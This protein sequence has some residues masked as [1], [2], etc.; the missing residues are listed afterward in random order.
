MRAC[1]GHLSSNL[2][3][4][5]LAVF[6]ESFS[7]GQNH[8]PRTSLLPEAS[9]QTEGQYLNHSPF[10]REGFRKTLRILWN[11]VFHKQRDTRPSAPVPVQTLTRAALIAAPNHSVYRL[12]HS[13]VLLKLRDKFW[14]TDPVFAERASPVQWAG[15][16]A[17]TSRRSASTS[18]HRLKR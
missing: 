5:L 9:R 10:K 14:I 17:F 16:S 13:T 6:P 12:G 15:P 1:L 8:F 3:K 7:H 2:E 11:M 4:P 18:C